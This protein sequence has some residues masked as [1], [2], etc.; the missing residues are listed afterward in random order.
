M[1]RR[2]TSIRV[3]RLKPHRSMKKLLLSI[4]GLILLNSA[5]AQISVN[6]TLQINIQG[7]PPG[8]QS[9]FSTY[10]VSEDGTIRM[11]IIGQVRASG[12]TQ[13][14]LAQAIA[15][16]YKS[17]GIYTDP[18]FTVIVPT[19][20]QVAA[21]MY[22]VGGQVKV[23]GQKPWSNNLTLYAAIQA[24][25]GE[26]PFGA[27]TRVKLFRSGRVFNYNLKEDQAKTVNVLPGD[28]IEVPQ[29]TWRG[30]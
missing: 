16:A 23:T 28:L 9:R 20:A 27:I 17:A 11:W 29:K 24:A 1:Q 15:E 5:S 19:D 25:G 7:V 22:T 10:Q 26:T 30:N 13:D 6:Q 2:K 4:L 21:K 18:N 3:A 12:R 8:E 14:Q